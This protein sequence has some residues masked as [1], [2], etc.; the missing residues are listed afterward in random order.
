MKADPG[1][2]LMGS[3]GKGGKHPVSILLTFRFSQNP[4]LEKYHCV[5]PNHKIVLRIL[6]CHV[7][8]LLKGQLLHQKTG[9]RLRYILRYSAGMN[10]RLKSQKLNQLL[11]SWRCGSQNHLGK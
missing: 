3:S 11:S 7:L 5:R 8:R 1:I 2:D 4:I 9:I 6:L 10:L